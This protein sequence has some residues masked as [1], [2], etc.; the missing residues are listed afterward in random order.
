ME[1]EGRQ[2]VASDPA[3]RCDDVEEADPG[4]PQVGGGGGGKDGVEGEHG[5]GETPCQGVD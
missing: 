3:A 4:R 1:D 5:G 2:Q